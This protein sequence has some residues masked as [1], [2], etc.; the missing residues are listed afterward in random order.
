MLAAM[1]VFLVVA[2]AVIG[3]YVA[4]TR[5]PTAV[6][7]HR[8]ELR[9]RDVAQTVDAPDADLIVPNTEGP[10]PSV[11]RLIAGSAAGSRLMRLIEQA[12]IRTTPGALLIISGA[13]GIAA[14]LAAQA[15]SQKLHG[16]SKNKI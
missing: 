8:L 6:A 1:L 11:D 16:R 9:L 15:G 4:A 3:I 12:G 5:L 2:G 10:L 14:M 7:R 13:L